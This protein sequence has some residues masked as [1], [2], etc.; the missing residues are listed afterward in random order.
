MFPLTRSSS[1]GA[2]TAALIAFT[3]GAMVLGACTSN[4]IP[5]T[6]TTDAQ[7]SAAVSAHS[8]VSG[9]TSLYDPP[10]AEQALAE[11]KTP[12]MLD[13]QEWEQQAPT[14]ITFLASNAQAAG[15]TPS[16]VTISD[17]VTTITSAGV[18]R[19]S[20]SYTGQV[21]V[22]APSDAL[23]VLI[24]DNLTI[25][26]TAGSAID[27]R[28][29]ANAV[30]LLEGQSTLAD[31][32]SYADSSAANAA[33]YAD[34]SLYIAGKGTLSVQGRGNDAIAATDDLVISS[35]TL[36]LQAVDDGIRGKDSVTITGGSVSI[37]A[38]GDGVKSDEDTDPSKG[39]IHISDGDVNVTAQ[40]DALSA[41]TDVIITDGTV[42]LTSGGG[43][44]ASVADGESAKGVKA[45]VYAI[46]EGG[47]MRIDAAEDGLHSDG[48]LRLRGGDVTITVADDGVHAEIALVADG[49]TVDIAQSTEGLEAEII[50]LRDGVISVVS[51]DD[52]IN[53]SASTGTVN[54]EIS[55]G[56]ITLD[57]EGD[58]LDA[59]GDLTIS[60]GTVVA[61]GPQNDGN[62]TV[63]VDGSFTVTGG[64]LLAAGSAGMAMFPT[65]SEIGW[66]S[67]NV[68]ASAG[69]TV[70]VRDTA[71]GEITTFTAK[72]AFANLLYAAANVPTDAE[73][74]VSVDGASTS[75]TAG[76][77]SAGMGPGGHGGAPGGA[78]GGAGAPHEG[79][80]PPARP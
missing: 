26:T 67:A 4:A 34:T 47:S 1:R 5:S 77:A 66:L 69:S 28:S 30:L 62:G 38:G 63:D 10:N 36:N 80:T 53:G 40:G 12:A 50:A 73:V 60:G 43:A 15:A 52:A 8:S 68:A 70:A 6:T 51:S 37:N 23:V 76:V 44:Q 56:T 55:G 14:T 59:N 71:G 31:A 39:F 49:T 72:K 41:Y 19:L 24:L 54:V 18:Y 16:S 58:A 48:S 78:P 64:T 79:G 57:A 21:V 11:N 2:S 27:V 29:A 3:A 45:G 7:S 35:G 22:E 42:S 17:N 75:V 74:T 13:A 33:V 65:S 9:S 20:G 32:S 61:W 25:D 46:I